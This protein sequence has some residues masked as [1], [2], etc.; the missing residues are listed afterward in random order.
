MV[1]EYHPDIIVLDMMLPD[2][3]GRGACQGGTQP[4]PAFDKHADHLHQRYG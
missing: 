3:N 1:K 2:I 4:V